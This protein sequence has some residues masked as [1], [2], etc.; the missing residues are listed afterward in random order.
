MP[1]GRVFSI[2][3]F[4]TYDGPGIR[5]TV[6]LKGCPLRCMWCHNPEGQRFE[7]EIARSPVGC[8]SCG[9][10]FNKG[11]ELTGKPSLVPESASVCPRSLVRVCGEDMSPDELCAKI[12]KNIAILNMSGGGVTF[13][14]GEPLCQAE[15]VLE[16]LTWLR[17]KTSRAIQTCGYVKNDIFTRVLTECDYVL[18]DLKLMDDQKHKHYTGVSNEMILQNYRTLAASGINFI[19]RIPLIPTV[20]DTAENLSATAQFMRE[21][22]ADR[23][24]LLPYNKLAGGKYRMLGRDYVTDFDEAVTPQTHMEIFTKYEIEVKVL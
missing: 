1:N 10:C 15:F 9:A 7:T 11:A 4:S 21:V 14:G 13:S 12:E 20:N 16:C 24:E 22:G 8:I 5:M 23:I 3:E 19:T 6:F 17:G 2:E 18:Y